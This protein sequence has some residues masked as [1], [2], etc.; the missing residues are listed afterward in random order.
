MHFPIV[1]NSM[2]ITAIISPSLY[3]GNERK[4]PEYPVEQKITLSASKTNREAIKNE[5]G[6]T[7]NSFGRKIN[8]VSDSH[9]REIIFRDVEHSFVLA[10][11]GFSEVA[12]ILA[13]GVIEELLRLYLDRV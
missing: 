13:G 5:Y 7:K 2:L 1:P 3:P 6:V 12:V 4:I 9:K 10:S 8:F 11:S